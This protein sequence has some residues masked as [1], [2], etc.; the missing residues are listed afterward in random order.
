MVAP[1]RA[2]ARQADGSGAPRAIGEY[3][4]A[5]RVEFHETDLAGLVHFSQYFI[6]V[7]EAE[8]AMWRAAGLSVSPQNGDVG[9]P[10]VAAAFEYHRPLRF[11]DVILVTLRITA[12]AR[13]RISYQ[14]TVTRDAD[15]I[16]TG[17]MTIACV[18]REPA[19][20]LVAT[21]IPATIAARFTVAD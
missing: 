14:A 2:R 5:R 20:A 9:W 17:H 18:R 10:R 1:E 6:Y 8:H 21:D 11:E 15:L 16:A 3:R 7:E 4:H 13:R 12:V 19:G